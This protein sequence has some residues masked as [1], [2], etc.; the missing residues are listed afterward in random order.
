MRARSHIYNEIV[1]NEQTMGLRVFKEWTKN[2]HN[3]ASNMNVTLKLIPPIIFMRD[4]G[5]YTPNLHL[6]VVFTPTV[7]PLEI[8][9]ILPRNG[10]PF[11]ELC[12]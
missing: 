12:Q 1:E 7:L 4:T 3:Y 6:V 5:S 10:P 8:P 9:Q 2:Y 11:F